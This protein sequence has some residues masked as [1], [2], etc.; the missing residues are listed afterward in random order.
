MDS[1]GKLRRRSSRQSSVRGI[2]R[3][4][5]RSLESNLRKEKMTLRVEG[6]PEGTKRE[7]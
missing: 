5:E 7:Q 6:A 4:V 2:A 3:K 1:L